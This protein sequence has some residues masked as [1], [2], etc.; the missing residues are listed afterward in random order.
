[1]TDMLKI[2][3]QTN[4]RPSV[5]ALARQ[6]GLSNTTFRRR[7]P[8]I[9]QELGTL[10]SAAASTT[11]GPSEPD[12]LIAR[13]AKLRR[14]NHGLADELALAIAQIQHLALRIEGLEEVVKSASNVTSINIRPSRR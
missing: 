2:C 1:M 10:R 11:D 13:N 6:L 4:T 9:A 14:R 8:D 5:L 3:C 7:F 12:R